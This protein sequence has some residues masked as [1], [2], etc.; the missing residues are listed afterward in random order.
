MRSGSEPRRPWGIL[1]ACLF[2]AGCFAHQFRT[3]PRIDV[4]DGDPIVE[5]APAERFPSLLRARMVPA[6]QQ[7]RPPDDDDRVLGIATGTSSRAYPMGLLDR[8]E[9]VDDFADD[10]PIVIVRCALTD[11]AAA[12]DRRV[13]GRSLVFEGTG[14]LWRDTLV[15]RDRETGTYWS[16]ANGRALSGPLAGE[17]LQGVAAAV[18]RRDRWE[19]THPETVFLD[20]G[21][22]P[23]TPLKIR[24][25]RF[26]SMHGVS[27][28]RTDD[29]R[30]APKQEM[31]A[32]EAGDRALA[33][34]GEQIERRQ[35]V[36]T[37]FA[38]DRVTI[39]WDGALAVPRLTGADGRERPLVTMYWFAIERHFS[40]VTT[41]TP[42]EPPTGAPTGRGPAAGES[43]T[44]R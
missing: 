20:A 38:G 30:H 5:M 1:I 36:V 29:R 32:F 43:S 40:S 15:F 24:L 44:G 14:A 26:S 39:A 16:A 33:F 10:R 18:T 21:V 7:E 4:V 11:V 9:V 8:F 12:W 42:P 6:T 3:S 34:T 31:F 2:A 19:E 35:S 22:E 25:Y 17:N 27:G 23:S 37:A 28:A 41:L 13:R